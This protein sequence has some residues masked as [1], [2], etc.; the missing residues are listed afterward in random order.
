VLVAL[1]CGGLLRS[2]SDRQRIYAQKDGLFGGKSWRKIKEWLWIC[3]CTGDKDVKERNS[4]DRGM[5]KGCWA[6]Q[7]KMESTIPLTEMVVARA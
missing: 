6:N 4:G 5:E 7:L 1:I 3:D 2:L